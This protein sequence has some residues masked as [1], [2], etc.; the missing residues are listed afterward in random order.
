MEAAFQ[1]D[2]GM[3]HVLVPGELLAVAQNHYCP[4]VVILGSTST[5]HHLLQVLM[6]M[7]VSRLSPGCQYQYTRG[8]LSLATLTC[9]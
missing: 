7:M 3:D 9:P 6:V 8:D 1:Q 5:A 2:F 4:R